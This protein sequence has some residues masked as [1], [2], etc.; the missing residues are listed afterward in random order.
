VAAEAEVGVAVAEPSYHRNHD[1]NDNSMY[2]V[3]Y[4][5]KFTLETV[6]DWSA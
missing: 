5:I 2:L 3:H 6:G 4:L 1:L